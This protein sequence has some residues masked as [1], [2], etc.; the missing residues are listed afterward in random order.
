MTNV[1]ILFIIL[2]TIIKEEKNMSRGGRG[3]V[4]GGGSTPSYSGTF[5]TELDKVKTYV[6]D[7]R[8]AVGGDSARIGT[9]GKVKQLCDNLLK[10]VEDIRKLL[11]KACSNLSG[12][13]D[14]IDAVLVA[15]NK[16]VNEFNGKLGDAKGIRG[17]TIP[18]VPSSSD[19]IESDGK[20][21][22]IAKWLLTKNVLTAGVETNTKRAEETAADLAKV[23]DSIKTNKEKEEAAVSVATKT[24]LEK[25]AHKTY[26]KIFEKE[27]E[28]A[29]E[30][31]DA[32]KECVEEFNTLKRDLEAL[33]GTE[34]D[35]DSTLDKIK[36]DV[37]PI[38]EKLSKLFVNKDRNPVLQNIYLGSVKDTI[39]DPGKAVYLSA[40]DSLYELN[41]VTDWKNC[42]DYYDTFLFNAMSYNGFIEYLQDKKDKLEAEN[43]S[44][45]LTIVTV[46]DRK[47]KKIQAKI[48]INKTY[49]AEL[50]KEIRAIKQA[51]LKGF[52]IMEKAYTSSKDDLERGG[53]DFYKPFNDEKKEADD[54]LKSSIRAFLFD[55]KYKVS[56]KN[57]YFRGVHGDVPT[58]PNELYEIYKNAQKATKRSV[59]KKHIIIAVASIAGATL[60]A[61]VGHHIA[62]AVKDHLQTTVDGGSNS[63]QIQ[64]PT[65]NETFEK[66]DFNFSGEQLKDI[67]S[68][69]VNSNIIL[70]STEI[71]GVKEIAYTEDGCYLYLISSDNKIIEIKS[72]TTKEDLQ[73]LDNGQYTAKDLVDVVIAGVNSRSA[74]RN[75][76][77]INTQYPELAGSVLA[78]I[79]E[80]DVDLYAY[81]DN[82]HSR[83]GDSGSVDIVAFGDSNA[84]VFEDVVSYKTSEGFTIGSQAELLTSINNDLANKST[85]FSGTIDYN[86]SAPSSSM[87][88]A[89]IKDAVDD[90]IALMPEEAD[91]IG[92]A[93]GR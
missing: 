50:E 60:L 51:V 37:A 89:S 34:P 80:K 54:R 76:I 78:H 3:V 77:G 83:K 1:S 55:N 49:I 81:V 2:Q 82:T 93:L 22:E 68:D 30:D 25:I 63:S 38:F 19:Y 11:D 40:E 32:V 39:K 53:E 79:D 91:Q 70:S 29:K 87:A 64:S 17:I 8:E 16:A 7:W 44:L 71:N 59:I 42:N 26:A 12:A 75:L 15:Y 13:W 41:T 67:K 45:E 88:S 84:Y 6:E 47:K 27:L 69:L 24:E 28:V 57:N 65:E 85:S 62:Q 36:N 33:T 48:D 61:G 72:A 10:A 20:V 92:N 66:I 5:T 23:Y 4:L 58:S 31:K 21:K 46:K 73:V 18:G 52:E 35:I 74:K 90:L 9:K 14:E 56:Y 43:R 86:F